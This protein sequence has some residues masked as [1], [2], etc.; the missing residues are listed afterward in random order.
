MIT[1]DV[2]TA[3]NVKVFL[4]FSKSAADPIFHAPVLGL[5]SSAD[6]QKQ[7]YRC[8]ESSPYLP[9]THT[10]ADS[11]GPYHMTVTGM[12]HK[13]MSLNDTVNSRMEVKRQRCCQLF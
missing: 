11:P 10:F 5:R 7:R 12:S 4:L 8:E 6:K 9:L 2:H 1:S 3:Q 13:Q